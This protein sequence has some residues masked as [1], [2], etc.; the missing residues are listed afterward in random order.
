MLLCQMAILKLK[1]SSDTKQQIPLCYGSVGKESAC[2]AQ[3]MWVQSLGQEDPLEKEMQPA[4]V[5]LPVKPHGQR[6]L[7][8]IEYIP[9][10]HIPG[11]SQ[12]TGRGDKETLGSS[13]PS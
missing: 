5:F 6:R 9:P 7:R 4:S 10:G 11:T 13:P 1:A 2:K 12:R 8:E 3:E